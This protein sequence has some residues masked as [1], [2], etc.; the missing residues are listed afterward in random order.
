[1]RNSS[2]YT[3]LTAASDTAD[4]HCD[5]LID[6]IQVICRKVQCSSCTVQFGS[7]DINIE[8]GPPKGTQSVEMVRVAAG[9]FINHFFKSSRAGPPI[10][11]HSVS[12]RK[13]VGFVASV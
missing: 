6:L 1:M 11:S 7:R 12:P 3:V 4:R 2:V 10:I 9:T 5:Y 13:V 8:T